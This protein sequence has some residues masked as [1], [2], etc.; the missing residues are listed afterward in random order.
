MSLGLVSAD[1]QKTVGW[2]DY[3]GTAVMNAACQDPCVGVASPSPLLYQSDSQCL[4]PAEFPDIP[5]L[6]EIKVLAPVKL[7]T[8]LRVGGVCAGCLSGFFSPW[9]N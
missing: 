4:S 3:L 5:M 8:M 1:E 6:Q 9:R 2:D 7:P